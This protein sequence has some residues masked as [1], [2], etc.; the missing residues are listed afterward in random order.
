M[1]SLG[2][3]GG[4]PHER[5]RVGSQRCALIGADTL[6]LECAQ[7]LLDRG[8]QVVAIVAGSA[9]VVKWSVARGIHVLHTEDEDWVAALR[10]ADVDLLFAVTHLHL[11]SPAAIGTARRMA[12]NFH[13]GP[14]PEYAGLNT[15]VWGLIDGLTEWGV[16]WHELTTGPEAG[17][18]TGNILVEHRFA[19]SPD[20][21]S[22]SLNTSNV[23]HALD[24]FGQLL[25]LVEHGALVG[26][27]QST[28]GI[29]RVY[30]R[31]NRPEAAGVLDW[32]SSATELQR[33]VR[34]LHFGPHSNSVG[35]ATIWHPTAPAIVVAADV[36]TGHGAPGTLLAC[37]ESHVDIACGVGALRITRLTHLHG[38]PIDPAQWATNAGVAVGDVLPAP[39]DRAVLT[40]AA[41]NAQPHETAI[42]T[43]LRDLQPAEFPWPHGSPSGGAVGTIARWMTV[44]LGPKRA[45]LSVALAGAA[46]TYGGVSLFVAIFVLAP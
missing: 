24:S 11:L 10:Y 35:S 5:A 29:R 30:R 2:N 1:N 36:V 37:T 17:V 27:S 6:L 40:V 33:L 41:S 39:M 46:L 14:L 20:E 44:T 38:V 8:H 45:I 32:H 28:E 15:P 43:T 3:I 12:I 4:E 21:T 19:L 13:D 34:A 9:R 26:V 23:E 25:D 18:D 7:L 22:L 16:T 42:A 31:A